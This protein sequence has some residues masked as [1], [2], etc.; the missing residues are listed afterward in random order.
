MLYFDRGTSTPKA[1]EKQEEELKHLIKKRSFLSLHDF[2]TFH[3]LNLTNTDLVR[4]L[5]GNLV[6]KNK[7]NT[8][9]SISP[10][11]PFPRVG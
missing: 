7:T 11:L 6:K 3:N 9:E 4:R 8:E 2:P 5:A 10:I 1:D